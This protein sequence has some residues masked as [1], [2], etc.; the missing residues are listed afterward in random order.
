MMRSRDFIMKDNYS[1]DRDEAGLDESYNEM[2]DAYSRVFTRC[3]LTFRPVEADNGAIGGTGSHE[4]TALCEY[5]ES[6]ICYCDSCNM[7]TT[8]EKAEWWMLRRMMPKC[9][10]L[11]KCI[12][13]E[14]KP[15]RR[16]QIPWD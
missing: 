6:Q 3:G 11:R 5:G 15:S 8:I 16:L 13:R 10:L 9:C 2:H 14:L 12:H 4:F 7:A 1:F